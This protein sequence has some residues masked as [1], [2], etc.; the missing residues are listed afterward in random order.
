MV[1]ALTLNEKRFDCIL[2][3]DFWSFETDKWTLVSPTGASV[4]IWAHHWLLDPE[5]NPL[6]FCEQVN[7]VIERYDVNQH[8]APNA[9]YCARSFW[10]R[11]R[12][13]RC[14]RDEM[15]AFKILAKMSLNRGLTPASLKPITTGGAL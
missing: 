14:T 9:E 13:V 15:Y 5:K 6:S 10:G 12:A 3:R 1:S 8:A 11:G 7:S 2:V 4:S